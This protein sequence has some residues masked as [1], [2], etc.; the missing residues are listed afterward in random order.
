MSR[1]R[2]F[3]ALL[4]L[5]F[6]AGCQSTP[7]NDAASVGDSQRIQRLISQ[8]ADLEGRLANGDASGDY[9]W[10]PL[11]W[12]ASYGGIDAI[13]TLL[14][15]GADP[16]AVMYLGNAEGIARAQKK[17]AAAEFISESMKV[18]GIGV[19]SREGNYVV[20][21]VTHASPAEAAGIAP[22]DILVAVNSENAQELAI[23]FVR[24]KLRHAATVT[25]LKPGEAAP[26]TV[27]VRTSQPVAA[28]S[29]DSVPA[30]PTSSAPPDKP[31]WSSPNDDVARPAAP[32]ADDPTPSQPPPAISSDGAH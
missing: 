31:W 20:S 11:G 26:R 32:S 9:Y 22:G 21:V 18:P 8:G 27:S 19:V 29:P 12:A 16:F 17:T 15:A 24:A 2:T 5:I 6:A 13:R 23:R 10:T 28:A 4:S 7:L 14:D 25:V 30:R 3:A 1:A